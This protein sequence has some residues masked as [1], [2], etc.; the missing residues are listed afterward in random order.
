MLTPKK[1][2]TGPIYDLGMNNGDDTDYY[3]KRGFEVVAVEANPALCQMARERFAEAIAAGRVSIIEAAIGD[4]EGDVTFH[5]NLDNHHWS[6]M[7]INWA[8]RDDS[9]CQAIKVQSVTLASLYARHGVPYFMKIDVEGADMMVL[10]QVAAHSVL[11]DFISIEDCRFGFDYARILSQVGY[12]AFQLVDQSEIAGMTDPVC[13]HV[14]P[15]GSSGLFGPDLRGGWEPYPE[16]IET[17]AT[18]VRT[19]EGVRLA[20]RTRWWDIHAARHAQNK[21]TT[22]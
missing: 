5:V 13:G 22:P 1:N 21:E 14:F 9:V 6:S 10:E 19:R 7:D 17:Y 15:K 12:E 16:F 20:P 2:V 18:T 3:L 8:G 11:P 4:H